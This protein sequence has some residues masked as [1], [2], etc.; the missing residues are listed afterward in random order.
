MRFIFDSLLL[1]W[2]FGYAILFWSDCLG[3]NFYSFTK[4]GESGFIK[5]S[6]NPQNFYWAVAIKSLFL[7][8]IFYFW[9]KNLLSRIKTLYGARKSQ[10]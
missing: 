8:S 1:F 7:I 4:Y 5:Y 6:E 2:V 9:L 3:G 10:I